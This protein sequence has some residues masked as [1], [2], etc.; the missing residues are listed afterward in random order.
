[1]PS[2]ENNAWEKDNKILKY[3]SESERILGRNIM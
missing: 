1:M 2:K 3:A